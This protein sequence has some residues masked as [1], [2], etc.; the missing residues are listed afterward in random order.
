MFLSLEKP[1]GEDGQLTCGQDE[2]AAQGLQEQAPPPPPEAR[3]PDGETRPIVTLAINAFAQQSKSL[4]LLRVEAAYVSNAGVKT[5]RTREMNMIHIC[6]S[7]YPH[8]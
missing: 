2:E 8:K 3:T 5:S 1:A 4:R 6:I 7:V